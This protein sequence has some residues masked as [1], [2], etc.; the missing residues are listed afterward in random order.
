[1]RRTFDTNV[2]ENAKQSM[3]LKFVYISLRLIELHEQT[4]EL[5]FSIALAHILKT[6]QMVEGECVVHSRMWINID[7]C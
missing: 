6:F 2:K 4:N 5:W 1:M 7:M 3:C